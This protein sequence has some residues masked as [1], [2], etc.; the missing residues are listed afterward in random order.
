MKDL[1]ASL[2]KELARPSIL[3]KKGRDFR[4]ESKLIFVL[5]FIMCLLLEPSL[6]IGKTM[7]FKV[8]SSFLL[9]SSYSLAYYFV[10]VLLIGNV[11]V[12][13]GHVTNFSIYAIYLI[14]LNI[15]S[16][17][18]MVFGVYILNLFL[19]IVF[20]GSPFM[21]FNEKTIVFLF[22]HML[23][24]TLFIQIVTL[25]IIIYTR[26]NLMIFGNKIIGIQEKDKKTSNRIFLLSDNE[27]LTF[28]GLNKEE[29]VEVPIEDFM[30]IKSEGHYIKIYYK[31]KGINGVAFKTIRNSIKNLLC[32]LSANIPI[33]RVHKSYLVNTGQIK[34]SRLNSLGGVVCLKNN[35]KI[36]LSRTFYSQVKSHEEN[37]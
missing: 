29:E 32:A 19:K 27:M 34:Y 3:S 25:V 18:F 24:I 13:E 7:L 26:Q 28:K 14:V 17:F 22:W 37:E 2:K 16:F 8:I 35:V 36:P 5:V 12:V 10:N 9:A 20:S 21:I 1:L 15:L 4:I 33:V 23:E 30:Y 6:L 31:T 11:K